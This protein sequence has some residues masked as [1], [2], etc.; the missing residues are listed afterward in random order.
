MSGRI[1][2]IAEKVH[3]GERLTFDDAMALE[4]EEVRSLKALIVERCPQVNS[5]EFRK[6][7]EDHH[8][9]NVG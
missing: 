8:T 2:Q 5:V 4:H 7:P 9:C 6:N 3:A 1:D